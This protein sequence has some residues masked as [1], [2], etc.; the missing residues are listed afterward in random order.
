M[1][2]TQE[3]ACRC[4]LGGNT[5]DAGACSS[6]LSGGKPQALTTQA[7]SHG[8]SG[9]CM[10]S[11]GSCRSGVASEPG[12]M[13]RGDM[14]VSSGVAAPEPS[15]PAGQRGSA[16]VRSGLLGAL[17]PPIDVTCH[18]AA[19]GCPEVRPVRCLCQCKQAKRT[20][21]QRGRT[22]H[23]SKPTQL[24]TARSQGASDAG[25]SAGW[26]T[27]AQSNVS[28]PAHRAS[29]RL[30]R[31]IRCQALTS[32]SLEGSLR[33]CRACLDRPT[34][35]RL[36]IGAGHLWRGVQC[37]HLAAAWDILS[38]SLLPH[39]TLRGMCPHVSL[40]CSSTH[41]VVRGAVA[42]CCCALA[43]AVETVRLLRKWRDPGCQACTRV[44]CKN[45]A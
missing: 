1:S 44:C 36:C 19:G 11:G 30:F 5:A 6:W 38:L 9:G 21:T 2:W 12:P 45:A 13:P 7:G 23:S 32:I 4:R 14:A 29:R 41:G 18:S 15:G 43:W 33:L 37:L 8:V 28:G 26:T 34:V 22:S 35:C 40:V 42:C 31:T 24:H 10:S 39:P 20:P 25:A 3:E 17:R 27:S 16:P